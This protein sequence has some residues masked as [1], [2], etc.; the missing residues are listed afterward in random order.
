MRPGAVR[1][2]GAIRYVAGGWDAATIHAPRAQLCAGAHRHV[3]ARARAQTA[4][5]QITADELGYDVDEIE[6][7][8]GDTAVSRSGMDT[9]GS[10]SLTVGGIALHNAAQKIVAKARTLSRRTSSASTRG[11]L[12]YEGGTFGTKGR[13]GDQ[14]AGLRRLVGA[15]DLPPGSS[16]A[17]GDGH[18]R[19]AELRLARRRP[20]RSSRST[21]RPATCGC[22]ATSRSTTSARP[23]T[24]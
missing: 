14:G 18:L 17:R 5:S 24:R 21:R 8:H 2:L 3:T 11:E 12:S 16:R 9:Y 1:I 22:S 15:H 13:G 10:R 6:V 4:W 7:M 23:S 20:R 19:P